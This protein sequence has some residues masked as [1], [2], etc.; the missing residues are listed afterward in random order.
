M[1]C[2]RTTHLT[3]TWRL[4]IANMGEGS[5]S[6]NLCLGLSVCLSVCMSVFLPLS[7]SLNFLSLSLQPSIPQLQQNFLSSFISY[8]DFSS[9]RKKKE[10]ISCLLFSFQSNGFALNI[11]IISILH[12]LYFILHLRDQNILLD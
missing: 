2:L 8:D 4:E 7:F 1:L 12:T 6:L 11:M 10:T 5:V 9:C 3:D